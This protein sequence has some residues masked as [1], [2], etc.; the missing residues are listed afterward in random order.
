MEIMKA[1]FCDSFSC[2]ASKEN[3]CLLYD[4]WSG[5]CLYEFLFSFTGFILSLKSRFR[6][7]SGFTLCCPQI[8]LTL[9][10]HLGHYL[11]CR[12]VHCPTVILEH[13]FQNTHLRGSLNTILFEILLIYAL[14][15]NISTDVDRSYPKP[16]QLSGIK[17]PIC[18]T[19]NSMLY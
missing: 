13:V 1:Q 17:T 16:Q 19:P 7:Q 2:L 15:N 11:G 5:V 14:P 18:L 12:G 3:N 8:L 6:N 4:V 9:E 10:P